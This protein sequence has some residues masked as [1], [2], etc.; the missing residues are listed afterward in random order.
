[1]SKPILTNNGVIDTNMEM[2]QAIIADMEENLVD[3]TR[4]KD[5]LM[6]AFNGKGA[7]SYYGTAQELEKRLDAYRGTITQ[8]KGATSGAAQMIADADTNVAKLFEG[9]V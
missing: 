1:M 3:L 2:V 8:L 6:T 7:D 4:I 5:A 9:Y